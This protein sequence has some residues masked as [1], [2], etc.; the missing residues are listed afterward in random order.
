MGTAK[1]VG[2]AGEPL[3]EALKWTK[4]DVRR[5]AKDEA[6]WHRVLVLLF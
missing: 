5:A 6:G 2:A 1:A 4:G 3:E